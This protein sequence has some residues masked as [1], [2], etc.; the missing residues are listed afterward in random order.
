MQNDEKI[1]LKSVNIPQIRK[2]INLSGGRAKIITLPKE[3]LDLIN[4]E[5]TEVEIKIM[6]M[7][8]K[9]VLL[10]IPILKGGLEKNESKTM[11]HKDRI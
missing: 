9:Y 5:F 3:F 1:A 10:V 8:D 6:Q 11:V 2:V 4:T 7:E